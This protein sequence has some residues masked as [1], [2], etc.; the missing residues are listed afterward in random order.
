MIC[1]Y[2][3]YSTES[4]KVGNGTIFAKLDW[5]YMAAKYKLDDLHRANRVI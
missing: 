5:S 1:S 2:V 3:V 4:G